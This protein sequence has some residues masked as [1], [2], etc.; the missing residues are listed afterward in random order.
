MG[1][2]PA[3]THTAGPSRAPRIIR[4]TEPGLLDPTQPSRL[5]RSPDSRLS[6]ASFDPR[7][8]L[9]G[10]DV[11][12]LHKLSI[13]EDLPPPKR[14]VIETNSKGRSFWRFVPKARLDEGARDEGF[15]PRV[16]EI[17]GEHVFCH[18]EQW[19]IYKL[20]PEYL[21]IV[22]FGFKFTSIEKVNNQ[23]RRS[24]APSPPGPKRARARTPTPEAD[25]PLPSKRARSRRAHV[26]SDDHISDSGS[27][28][29]EEEVKQMIVDDLPR[30]KAKAPSNVVR[31]GREEL[32]K[33]RDK[34]WQKIKETQTKYSQEPQVNGQP[35]SMDAEQF[36][37]QSNTGTQAEETAKRKKDGF[38]ADTDDELPQA[39]TPTNGHARKRHRTTSPGQAKQAMHH[40]KMHREM[41]KQAKVRAIDERHQQGFK[42]WFA[43]Y[44]SDYYSNNIDQLRMLPFP[45]YSFNASDHERPST[46]PQPAA[47]QEQ[48]ESRKSEDE[49]LNEEAM[50]RAELAESIR[51]MRELDRDRPLWEEERRKRE[52]HERAEEQ[53]RQSKAEQRRK[54]EAEIQRQQL[55]REEAERQAR[56]VR[57]EAERSA[58]EE[59]RRRQEQRRLRQ[60]QRWEFGIWTSHRAL[61]RYKVLSEEFDT[62]RFT[63]DQPI[64]FLDIPWPVLHHPS[65]LTVEDVDWSAVEKFFA[66]VKTSMRPQD[67][68]DFVERSHRRFHPDR[69]RA[70]KVW[71]AIRD[72]VERGCLEVAANTVAQAITPIWREVKPH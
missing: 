60:R 46:S 70:R 40:S 55:E 27:D 29:D 56:R 2:Q 42:H 33:E 24:G 5:L 6:F 39:R 35:M 68:K 44:Y 13:G 7:T 10:E 47:S 59:E 28:E 38:A 1:S 58:A 69:W 34:R 67:Y 51:K 41:R 65:C 15:W 26:D 71:S 63:P 72:D 9:A 3:T 49:D 36:A 50:R 62:T 31:P 25:T 14:I 64:A 54:A 12:D 4:G 37:S 18:Q 20:D 30:P 17:C 61:E 66:T 45:S 52:A 8:A 23:A 43:D 32:K 22:R 19:E 48:S 16:V 53:E 21:C 11:P 57:A